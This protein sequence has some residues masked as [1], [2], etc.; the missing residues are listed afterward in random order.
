MGDA[1]EA[2]AAIG[3][4]VRAVGATFALIV[5]IALGML[6]AFSILPSRITERYSAPADNTAST[7]PKPIE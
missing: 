2:V 5:A 6:T 7:T 4:E 3:S 1:A